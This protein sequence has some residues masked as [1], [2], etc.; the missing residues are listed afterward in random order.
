MKKIKKIIA[1][2]L[3]FFDSRYRIKYYADLPEQIK[4]KEVYIIGNLKEPW[5]LMF[6]CPC[7]CKKIIQLNLL[8]EASPQWTFSITRKNRMTISP[9]ISG[10]TGCQSHFF[11]INN[12]IKWV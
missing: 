12:K 3:R 1:Y 10:T 6:E 2:I 4:K 9:S 5:L 11:L 7:G 8:K